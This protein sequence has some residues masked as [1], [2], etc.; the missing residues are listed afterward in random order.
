M[1]SRDDRRSG[2]GH[3]DWLTL[4]V[5]A[6]C[7]ILW[8]TSLTLYA[9]TGWWPVL[10]A[11]VYSVTLHSSLQ[12]EALHGHPT[13]R[14]FLNELLVFPALGLYIPYRR[15]RATHL[16]HHCDERLT[17]P[18]D[19]PESWYVSCEDWRHR[20]RVMRLLLTFNTTLA[21]RLLIGPALGVFGLWRHDLSGLRNGE[22]FVAKAYLLHF[23]GAL[24]VVVASQALAG[25]NPLVYALAIA[26]PA[27]SLLMVRTFAEHR[28]K[29]DPHQRSVIIE[30]SPFFSL[31]F[32]NNNLHYAHH[33]WPTKPWYRLGADYRAE[34]DRLLRENGGY[35]FDG[36]LA[37]FRRHLFHRVGPVV[38]PHFRRDGITGTAASPAR[39]VARVGFG[40]PG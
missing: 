31:L 25:I 12:H 40:R 5:L 16:R 15:F 29:R 38:H 6:G 3:I 17:D 18:Y 9:L 7:Y 11:T 19:D 33:K 14:A 8:A 21:G 32:L 22:H 35:R 10:A 1:R 37:L 39:R 13:R 27:M 28:P 30:T 23:A 36:Y 2:R 26:Y 4:V 34:K 24:P 20:G